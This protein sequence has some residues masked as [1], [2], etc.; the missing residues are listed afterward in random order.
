MRDAIEWSF[1]FKTSGGETIGPDI[2]V[3]IW[4]EWVSDHDYFDLT[5]L[6]Y[7]GISYRERPDDGAPFEI[8]LWDFVENALI[9][10]DDL[11]GTA[12][13]LHSENLEAA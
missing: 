4:P 5:S 1:Q 2:E 7:D 6:E 9:N 13:R 3:N 8:A 11:I 12:W 10:D